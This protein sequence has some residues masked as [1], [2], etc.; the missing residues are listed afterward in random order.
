MPYKTISELPENVRHALPKHALDIYKEAFNA[1]YDKYD[2]PSERREGVDR[3]EVA[4]MIAW[5]A[6]KKKYQKGGDGKWQPKP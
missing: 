4:H 6:V 3:E 1:A 5:S 2:Q